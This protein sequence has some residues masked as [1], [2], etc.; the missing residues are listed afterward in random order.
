MTIADW[1]G[2]ILTSLSILAIIGLAIR[3]TLKHYVLDILKELKPNGGSSIKD[4]VNRLEKELKEIK[5]STD[6]ADFKRREMSVKLDHLYELFVDYL[7][8][9][10]KTSTNARTKK[11]AK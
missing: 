6:E 9:N 1:L 10:Q 11:S 2:I 8:S 3:W 7:A 4:Q 5:A